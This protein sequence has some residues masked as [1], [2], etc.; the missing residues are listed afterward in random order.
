LLKSIDQLANEV[1][2]RAEKST[3]GFGLIVWLVAKENNCFYLRGA[4]AK[5]CNRRMQALQA[6][7]KRRMEIDA[8]RHPV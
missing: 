7:K 6:S 8:L 3:Q 2:A 5:E 1:I 4:I